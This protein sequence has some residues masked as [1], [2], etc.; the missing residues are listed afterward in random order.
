MEPAT[1]E[2]HHHKGWDRRINDFPGFVCDHHA[3]RDGCFEIAHSGRPEPSPNA[4]SCRPV[5]YI[6]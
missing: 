5:L 3:E 1:Q 4:G 6:T 2:K